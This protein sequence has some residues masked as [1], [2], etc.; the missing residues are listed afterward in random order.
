MAI[1]LKTYYRTL[2]HHLTKFAKNKRH[3]HSYHKEPKHISHKDID[4]CCCDMKNPRGIIDQGEP[5]RQ[6]RIED[7]RN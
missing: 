1:V 5:Y 6:Q 2:F 7:A 4:A 3:P